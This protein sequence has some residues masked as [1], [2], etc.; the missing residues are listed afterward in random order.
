MQ[1]IEIHQFNVQYNVARSLLNSADLQRRL[2]HIAINL[3][4]RVWEDK[5]FHTSE[6]D[7]TIYF[8]QQID[9]NLTCDPHK[10]DDRQLAST[11]ANAL[12]NN[13]GKTI[14]QQDNNVIIFRNR[15]EFLASFVVDLLRGRAWDCWYY[16]EFDALR[17]FSL[18][19]ATLNVLMADG[20]IG[21]DALLQVTRWGSLDLLLANLNDREVETI[22][23]RCLLPPSPRVFLPST[24]TI[25]LQNLLALLD[26]RLNLTSV[27]SRDVARLY[28]NLIEQRPELGPDVNLARFIRD[29]LQLWQTVENI[30]HRSAF[31]SHLQSDNR[32]AAFSQLGRGSPQQLLTN[33]MR[34]FTGTEVVNLLSKLTQK[35]PQSLSQRVIT[36]FGGIFLLVGAIAELK[37]YDF[38]Q[39]CVYPEPPGIPKAKLF[40]WLIALQCLG[41][42]N[43]QQAL[44]ER[45]LALFAGL[46]SIPES[47]WLQAYLANLTAA[48]HA[49][50]TQQFQE[51]LR[52]VTQGAGMFIY[53]RALTSE[54][55][56]PLD[57]FSLNVETI[58]ILPNPEVNLALAAVSSAIVRGFTAKLGAFSNSSPAYI[59]TN[60]LASQAEIAVSG[61][62]IQVRF[63]TCPLQMVLRMAGFEDFRW[64]IPWLGV[65]GA[66]PLENR[67][68]IFTFD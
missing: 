24:V 13:I 36:P 29:L 33:L 40:L 12:S 57:W 52:A 9:V 2:D 54:Q 38:L 31:F 58:P 18:S 44:K 59:Y 51:H 25:W 6:T 49:D 4:P 67:Q 43:T 61:S 64:Q 7:E 30:T 11:W 60:F 8:I 65:G 20:D 19:Q 28:L 5:I 39:N 50:F 27:L 41:G 55:H 15:G 45:S 23:N 46:A 26:N 10:F 63:L 68:L 32:N 35:T 34:E 62:Q 17:S 66:S 48:M 1:T 37:I 3:L 21:R 22:V 53:Q 56:N 47:G 16:S 42:E 14:S